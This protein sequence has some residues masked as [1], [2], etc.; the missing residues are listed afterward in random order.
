MIGDY[1]LH[2]NDD[3]L[4]HTWALIISFVSLWISNG[5]LWRLLSVLNK[6]S[7]CVPSVS[8]S[9]RIALRRIALTSLLETYL[10]LMLRLNYLY[11]LLDFSIVLYLI[12]MQQFVPPGAAASILLLLVA[13][14]SDHLNLRGP[15]VFLNFIIA[16]IGSLILQL[17]SREGVNFLL[18]KLSKVAWRSVFPLFMN[19]LDTW[20]VLSVMPVH[21]VGI[22]CCLLINDYTHAHY[23]LS[24][25]TYYPDLRAS[26]MILYY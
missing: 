15:F 6:V 3:P 19:R 13:F 23:L 18:E 25:Y 20:V 24:K 16:L 1:P 22:T 12:N 21:K 10:S 14:V 2:S 8:R 5:L 7:P 11:V 9:R 4:S 26:L 17:A